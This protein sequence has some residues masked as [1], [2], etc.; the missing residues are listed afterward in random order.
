RPGTPA[1]TAAAQL[2]EAVKAERLA[3]L[4]QLLGEQQ[5]SF[6]QGTIGRRLPVLLERPGKRPGQLSGRSPYMQSVTVEAPARLLGRIVEVEIVEA[7]P[8]SLKGHVVTDAPGLQP[9]SAA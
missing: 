4:Q 3:M 5:M 8:N 6:N 1:A 2:P 9:A 7:H